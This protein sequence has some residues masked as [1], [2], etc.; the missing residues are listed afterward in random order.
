MQNFNSPQALVKAGNNL[1]T[2]LANAGPITGGEPTQGVA[3]GTQGTGLLKNYVLE[4]SNV[5]LTTEFSSLISSQRSFQANARMITT[6]DDILQ[7]LIN[8]K[9]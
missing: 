9:R 4:G 3:P 8:L 5:D 2:N 7:E 6:S 1:Y